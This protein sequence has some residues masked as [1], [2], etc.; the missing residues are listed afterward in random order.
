MGM[1]EVAFGVFPRGTAMVMATENAY[2]P[3]GDFD[4]NRNIIEVIND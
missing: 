2:V 4:R 3:A 1:L